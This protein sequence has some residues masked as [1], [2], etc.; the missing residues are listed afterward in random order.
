MRIC[1][2]D[3]PGDRHEL[4]DCL[5]LDWPRFLAR[6]CPSLPWIML[7]NIGSEITAYAGQLGIDRLIFSGGEE[8]G[9]WPLRDITEQ[10][11][12]SW[13]KGMPILGICRGAQVINRLLGGRAQPVSGHVARYHKILLA[14]CIADI[15]ECVVNSYHNFG[16]RPDCLAPGLVPF[17]WSQ[18][19]F[20]E[21]FIS[22]DSRICGI[23]WHP[24]RD[25][26]PP[27]TDTFLLRHLT[28]GNEDEN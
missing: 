10:H 20:I 11:L 22:A 9:Q 24:E 8:W 17:A 7:P 21:G 16:I 13:A 12:F 26:C 4:R 1:R 27:E 5:A 25:G 18:D 28:Q 6:L 2:K 19:G 3:Y 15:S 23:M 14:S